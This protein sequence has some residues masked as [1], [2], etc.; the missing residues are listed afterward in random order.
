[1]EATS[2][3]SAIRSGIGYLPAERRSQGLIM[4]DTVGRNMTLGNSERIT[5]RGIV[6]RHLE[7]RLAER[8]HERLALKAPSIGTHVEELS[9]GTQQKVLLARWLIKDQ[10][11]LMLD[12]PTRGVDIATKAEIYAY[13]RQAAAAGAAVLVISSDPEE[14]VASTDRVVVLR[15]G[16]TVADITRATETQLVATAMTA[17]EGTHA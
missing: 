10:P 12:E 1:V 4:F 11:V 6:R 2:P 5:R 8:W 14:L 9:G 15:R 3:R 17:G 7:T 13:L 16:R